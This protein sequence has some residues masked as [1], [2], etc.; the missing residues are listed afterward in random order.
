MSYFVIGGR[1]E[2]G[3]PRSFIREGM[4]QM[5]GW[6][7]LQDDALRFEVFE[8]AKAYLIVMADSRPAYLDKYGVFEVGPDGVP[9]LIWPK[10]TL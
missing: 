4:P 5:P 1:F 2:P 7:P 8:Q 10:H 3:P 9:V 6:T